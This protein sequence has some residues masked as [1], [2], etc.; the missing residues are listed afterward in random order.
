[1]TIAIAAPAASATGVAKRTAS[2][3]YTIASSIGLHR[4]FKWNEVGF[5][6]EFG[7]TVWFPLDR[8]MSFICGFER[9]R[10]LMAAR[11]SGRKS[12]RVAKPDR[13]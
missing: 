12:A 9:N 2:F 5:G 6:G 13:T 4:L 7:D 1:M 10:V 11:I 8:S 3:H